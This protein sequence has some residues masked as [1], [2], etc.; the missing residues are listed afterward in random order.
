MVRVYISA[1]QLLRKAC[2]QW[3]EGK[4]YWY[5]F[6]YDPLKDPSGRAK[7]IRMIDTHGRADRLVVNQDATLD[8]IAALWSKLLDVPKEVRLLINHHNGQDFHWAYHSSP[9]KIPCIFR[10]PGD[11]GNASVID[12]PPLFRA[13]QIG[14]VLD[15]KCPPFNLCHISREDQGP[16]IIDFQGEVQ[17]LG[18][19]ILNEHSLGWNVEGR[20]IFD[21]NITTWWLPYDLG[22]IMSHGH[23]IDATIPEDVNQ[24][25]FPDFPWPDR[26]VIRIKSQAP[27][28]VPAAPLPTSGARALLAPG[29]PTGWKGAALGQAQPISADASGLA[30]YI[31][32]NQGQGSPAGDDPSDPALLALRG[33][34]EAKKN[35]DIHAM[36]SWTTRKAYPLMVCIGLP[37]KYQV[38]E[39]FHE[40]QFWEEATED[41]MAEFNV[42]A[43]EVYKWLI[44]RMAG[45]TVMQLLPDAMP[46]TIEEVTVQTWKDGKNGHIL[47]TPNDSLSVPPGVME[48]QVIIEYHLGHVRLGMG[49]AYTIRMLAD[50]FEAITQGCWDIYPLNGYR[51]LLDGAVVDVYLKMVQM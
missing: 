42:Q 47:F 45:R 33:E 36:I 25:I 29:S 51:R 16:V 46:H 49:N 4:Q 19:R 23:S 11:Q 35:E 32:P 20:T 43:S 38:G 6:T 10:T 17:R 13:E 8:E 39:E 15:I 2:K 28:Q 44:T 18:L 50:E 24:A 34:T 9:D 40:I 27:P 41:L 26:V 3:E 48:I 12:G 31:S 21:R 30:D 22:A 5:E 14:R 1:S 7:I 37:A